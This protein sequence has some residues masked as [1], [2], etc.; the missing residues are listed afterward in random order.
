MWTPRTTDLDPIGP[1]WWGWRSP[2]AGGGELTSPSGTGRPWRSWSWSWRTAPTRASPTCRRCLPR[3]WRG[4]GRSLQDPAIRKVGHKLKY[5]RI[6]LE[7][8][9]SRTG[10]A[11]LRHHGGVVP[12]GPRPAAATTWTCWPSTTWGSAP[13]P[14]RRWRG[15]AEAGPPSPRCRL[16]VA[17]DYACEHTDGAPP[18][19]ALPPHPAGQR[20]GAPLPCTG[21]A[22][23]PILA[24]MERNGIR[25]DPGSSRDEPALGSGSWRRSS[26]TSM[27]RRGE[28]STSTRCRSSRESSSSGS[29][30]PSSRRR[31]PG[32]TDSEC[33]RRWRGR[34]TGLRPMIEYRTGEARN[35]YVDAA[36]PDGEPRDGADPYLRSIRPCP[37]PGASP[38]AIPTSR[39]SPSGPP[40]GG[41]S[42]GASWQTQGT[43]FLAVRLLPGEAPDPGPTSPG[44]RPS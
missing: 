34:G 31:R 18:P 44:T 23:V 10:G 19:G 9:G 41:R 1:G 12:G 20:A 26:T 38:P 43:V 7:Q 27:W 35:T 32:S 2:G 42:A 28:S 4:S 39:T 17:R 6:V 36:S 16:E 13:P 8:E 40:W 25:I 5:D 24:R 22:P 21:D 37:R 33:W 29:S 14:T 30:S 15:R 11:G 3:R